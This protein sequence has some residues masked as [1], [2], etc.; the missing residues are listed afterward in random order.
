MRK[1]NVFHFQNKNKFETIPKKK[2]E[3]EKEKK[4]S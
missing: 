3:K 2:E 1:S 4:N